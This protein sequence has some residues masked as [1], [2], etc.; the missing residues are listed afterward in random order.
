M[1]TK[2]FSVSLC[3]SIEAKDETEAKEKFFKRV[4]EDGYFNSDSV[5]VEFDYSH[6]G[7]PEQI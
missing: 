7:Y 3:L 2:V 5:E 4:H 6:T 1:E